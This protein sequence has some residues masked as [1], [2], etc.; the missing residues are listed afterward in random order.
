ME[1]E[2][3]HNISRWHPSDQEYLACKRAVAVDKKEQ[4][5]QQVFHA[6]QRRAFLLQM[7]AKY[8]GNIK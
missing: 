4:L 1:F 5:L 7:K 3:K 6:S 8:A 2:R